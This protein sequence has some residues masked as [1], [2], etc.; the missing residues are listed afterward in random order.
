MG[1]GLGPAASCPPLGDADKKDRSVVRILERKK[2]P[3]KPNCLW[4][5][6]IHMTPEPHD[7]VDI[8]WAMH[9]DTQTHTPHTIQAPHSTHTYSPQA[10]THLS[11]TH[12]YTP[13]THIHSLSPTH[14]HTSHPHIPQGQTRMDTPHGHT[15][16][17]TPFTHE[18]TTHYSHTHTT[19]YLNTHPT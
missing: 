1:A 19:C 15:D 2:L 11:H 13:H 18:Y 7:F 12:T 8:K 14:L 9:T 10:H 16:I 5:P 6:L 17:H 4:F 3:Q